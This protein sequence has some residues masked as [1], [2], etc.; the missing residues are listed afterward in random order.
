MSYQVNL[1]LIKEKRLEKGY[2]YE[3]TA[4]LLGLESRSMYFK[5]EAGETSFKNNELPVLADILGI[6]L[7]KIFTHNVEEIAMK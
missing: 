7:K 4:N 3:K 5:R 6:D 2:T 1:K